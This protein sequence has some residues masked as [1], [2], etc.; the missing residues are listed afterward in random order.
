MTDHLIIWGDCNT[1]GAPHDDHD[2]DEPCLCCAGCDHMC[3]CDKCLKAW[4]SRPPYND[5]IP[6]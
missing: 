1:C 6:F 2:R 5:E 4:R 3:E